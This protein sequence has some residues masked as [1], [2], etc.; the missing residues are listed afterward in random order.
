MTA[1]WILIRINNWRDEMDC[2]IM[3]FS[4]R[5]NAIRYAAQS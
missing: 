4:Q 2:T 5:L 3:F 1:L